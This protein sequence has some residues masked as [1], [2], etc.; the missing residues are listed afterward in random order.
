MV[1][2]Q[3]FDASSEFT[4][5]ALAACVLEYI[6]QAAKISY[7]NFVD[8]KS[9]VSRATRNKM[10]MGLEICVLDM[11]DPSCDLQKFMWVFLKCKTQNPIGHYSFNDG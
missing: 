9:G 5:W 7:R 4:S 11:T 8:L 6:K 2:R 10:A 3:A 1:F